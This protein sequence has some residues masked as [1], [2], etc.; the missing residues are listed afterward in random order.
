[1]IANWCV[2]SWRIGTSLDMKQGMR[3]LW[4]ISRWEDV[5]KGPLKND[6][7]I[8]EHPRTGSSCS[9]PCALWAQKLMGGERRWALVVAPFH[10]R[11]SVIVDISQVITTSV[12]NAICRQCHNIPIS[13]RKLKCLASLQMLADH[14]NPMK[15]QPSRLEKLSQNCT[16]DCRKMHLSGQQV[17]AIVFCIP[18]AVG[19]APALRARRRKASFAFTNRLFSCVSSETAK[20]STLTGSQDLKTSS[21][22]RRAEKMSW[23][24]HDLTW[25]HKNIAVTKCN[26]MQ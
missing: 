25:P 22:L 16:Q 23:T 13:N 1:M 21:Y 24:S 3:G 15:L 6:G 10:V 26:R 9:W 20:F 19:I 2:N 5:T 7:P 17:H 8:L 11:W 18:L 14:T 12:K 4:S